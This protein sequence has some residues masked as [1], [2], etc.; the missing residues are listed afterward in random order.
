VISLCIIQYQ[1]LCPVENDES[2]SR[3][4]SLRI[5]A[6]SVTFSAILAAASL[7]SSYP[8]PLLLPI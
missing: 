1:V 4:L 8:P 5:D 3:A 2:Q 7:Y 6:Y